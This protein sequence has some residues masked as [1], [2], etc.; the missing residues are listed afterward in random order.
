MRLRTKQSRA[1]TTAPD[2]YPTETAPED[3]TIHDHGLHLSD[4]VCARCQRPITAT[5]E[6]RRTATGGCVHLCC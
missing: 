1:E 2:V 6:A 5:D 4:E 3:L